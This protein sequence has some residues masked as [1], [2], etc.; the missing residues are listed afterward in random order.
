MSGGKGGSQ[1]TKT[2]IP[3]YLRQGSQNNINA[4]QRIAQMGYVPYYGP[5]VA[6]ATPQMQASWQGANDA[7]SAFGMQTAQPQMPQA[8]D[9]GGGLMGYSS[10][11]GY[12]A[13]LRELAARQPEKFAQMQRL[14]GQSSPQQAA[15]QAAPQPAI[16]Q[17]PARDPNAWWSS[18]R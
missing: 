17:R 1:T 16:A 15:P 10:G 9:F 3:E 12:D 2:E 5:D 18:D 6:A 7:A 13:A 4:S 11:G 14:F 8:Q